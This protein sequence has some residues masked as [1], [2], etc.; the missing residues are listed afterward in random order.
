M[1]DDRAPGG[2]DS[3]EGWI[4][5]G[6]SPPGRRR[7]GGGLR[8]GPLRR[9]D[10]PRKIVLRDFLI[11]ELKLL[12]DGAKSF[13]ITWA[14]LGAVALDMVAPGDVPG[15]RFYAVMRLGERLDRW[16]SLYGI[17]DAA[18]ADAEGMF[19]VS[20]AGS[21][22]LLGRVEA[23][24]H[25][26]VVGEDGDFEDDRAA[27]GQAEAARPATPAA[28]AAAQQPAERSGVPPV[29]SYVRAERATR[30]VSELFDRALA[31]LDRGMDTLDRE[32]T[33]TGEVAPPAAP[34]APTAQAGSGAEA[35]T[36]KAAETPG[37]EADESP[38]QSS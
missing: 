20:R 9:L 16:L 7:R 21:P 17:A 28:P 35:T 27:A 23:L 37:A 30:V 34:P 11:Y 10:R 18:E 1:R 13:A 31:A 32:D 5:E 8:A 36:P 22:T 4:D 29:P 15:R 25:R 38:P 33:D 12:L 19:G 26:A 2:G 24:V 14:A 6:G 3:S